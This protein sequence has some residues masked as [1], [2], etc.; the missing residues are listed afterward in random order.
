[1]TLIAYFIR[2]WQ[3]LQLTFASMS[4]F[5]VCYFFLVPESPRWYLAKGKTQQAKFVLLNI[6]RSNGVKSPENNANF[7]RHFQAL[8]QKLES[9]KTEKQNLKQTLGNFKSL[10]FNKAYLQRLALMILPWFAV[11]QA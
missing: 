2:D 7:N 3:H 10:L 8:S 9:N 5:L 4:L 11:G 6:A 1:M